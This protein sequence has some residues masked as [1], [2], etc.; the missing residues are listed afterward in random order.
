MHFGMNIT[1]EC[2]LSQL[3]SHC[4]IEFLMLSVIRAL[5]ESV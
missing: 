1:F 3:V 5:K 2:L 4:F